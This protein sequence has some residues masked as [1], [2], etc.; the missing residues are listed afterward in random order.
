[1]R[2]GYWVDFIQSVTAVILSGR[3]TFSSNQPVVLW[4]T[5]CPEPLVLLWAGWEDWSILCYEMVRL[6]Q[7]LVNTAE[8]SSW[9]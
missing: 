7:C 8:H 6:M 3:I 2:L 9:N 5:E 1:M 4:V